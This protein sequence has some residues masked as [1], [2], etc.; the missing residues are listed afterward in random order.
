MDTSCSQE[1]NTITRQALP[2]NPQEKGGKTDGEVEEDMTEAV[3]KGKQLKSP[4]PCPVERTT[5]TRSKS[6]NI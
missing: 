6:K 2:W 5:Y 1:T 3:C 4:K